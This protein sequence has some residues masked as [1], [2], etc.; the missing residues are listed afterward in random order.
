MRDY[1]LTLIIDPE[2]RAEDQKK[3]ITKIKKLVTDFKGKVGKVNEWGKKEFNYPIKKKNMGY[4][5]CLEIGL[6]VEALADLDKKLRLEEAVCRFLLV[7]LSDK[8]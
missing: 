1:E 5:F 3:V 8:K 2:L 4:Y 6:P 7:S